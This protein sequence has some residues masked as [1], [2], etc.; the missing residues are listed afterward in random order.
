[1]C[2]LEAF[3]SHLSC[4][5]LQLVHGHSRLSSS[6]STILTPAH[7][8]LASAALL[9]LLHPAFCITLRMHCTVQRFTFNVYFSAPS[10]LKSRTQRQTLAQSIISDNLIITKAIEANS[11]TASTKTLDQRHQKLRDA[12][13]LQN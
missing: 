9:H 1:M 4:C 12:H 3:P 6:A 7:W 10:E 13:M 11:L 8:N 5:C 2:S